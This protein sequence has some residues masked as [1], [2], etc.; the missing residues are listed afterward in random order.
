MYCKGIWSLR[1][2]LDT[3]RDPSNGGY[4]GQDRLGLLEQ[5][6]NVARLVHQ[7]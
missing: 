4:L 1:L 2:W 3:F 7:D 6:K 5:Y